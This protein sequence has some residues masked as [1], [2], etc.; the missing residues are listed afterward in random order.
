MGKGGRPKNPTTI[1]TDT[2]RIER[3]IIP[4]LGTR[5]VKDLTKANINEVLKDIMAGKTRASVKTKKL[6]EKAIVAVARD[7]RRG[8]SGFS[9]AFSRT[10]VEAGIS[11]NPPH[12]LR[13]PKDNVRS[14]RLAEAEYRTLGEILRNAE[15]KDET[16]VTTADIIRR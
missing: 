2:A 12:G 4:L 6:R 9:A 3:H 1:I 8:P 10:H 5:R 11:T 13:K 14:R 7:R 15:K 16:Y